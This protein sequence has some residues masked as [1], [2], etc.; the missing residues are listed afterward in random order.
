MKDETAVLFERTF[1]S[2]IFVIEDA[3]T[4]NIRRNISDLNGRTRNIIT[5]RARRRHF[6]V[7]ALQQTIGTSKHGKHRK[8]KYHSSGSEAFIN[9][10]VVR[11][12]SANEQRC[13]EESDPATRHDCSLKHK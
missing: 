13:D 11:A 3:H 2:L 6:E 9:N 8:G 5:V 7:K 10:A 4:K 12:N 1:P